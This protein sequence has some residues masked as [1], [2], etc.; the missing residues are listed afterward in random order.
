MSVANA[1]L[2]IKDASGFYWKSFLTLNQFRQHFFD[3]FKRDERDAYS[4]NFQKLLEECAS[5]DELEQKLIPNSTKNGAAMRAIPFGV[6]YDP[7][8]TVRL[9]GLQARVTHDTQEGILSAQAVAIMSHFALHVDLP[10]SEI[11]GWCEEYCD[12]FADFWHDWDGPVKDRPDLTNDRGVGVNTA[13]AVC[14]L[15]RRGKSLMDIM[16]QVL[17]WGGDTDSVGSLA[18][19]IASAR[20]QDEKLPEFLERDLETG[21]KYGPKFLKDLGKE[22]MDAYDFR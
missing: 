13:W 1:E 11:T 22:L 19:G 6:F 2:L 8:E 17:E 9:A 15:L 4:R 20:F 10:L 5:A 12:L 21:R 16:R 18:W 14:T 3:V 7:V